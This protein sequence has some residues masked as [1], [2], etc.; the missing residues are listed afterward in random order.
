VTVQDDGV[1]FDPGQVGKS[2]LGLVGMR[3]RVL[4]VGG[5][6]DIDSAPGRGTTVV[7]R[8]PLGA[9]SAHEAHALPG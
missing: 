7:V 2:S 9:T 5:A 3:E 8:V 6:I 4:M 1:G